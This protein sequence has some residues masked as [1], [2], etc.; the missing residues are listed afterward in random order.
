MAQI[1]FVVLY[2]PKQLPTLLDAWHKS[3][4]QGATVLRSAG[5]YSVENW[6]QKM[7][8][9]ALGDLFNDDEVRTKTV[10]SIFEDDTLL[11]QAIAAA[12]KAIGSFKNEKTGILFTMPVSYVDG[13][14]TLP[15]RETE[16]TA[17]LDPYL[18][19][20]ELVTRETLIGQLT[21]QKLRKAISVHPNDALIDVAEKIAQTP[22]ATIA[23]VVNQRGHL[24]GLLPLRMLMDDLFMAVVPEAFLAESTSFDKVMNFA[25]LNQTE[26]VG[27]AMMPP[28][29]VTPNNT[30]KDAFIRMHENQISGIPV[31]NEKQEVI[32]CLDRVELL[33]FYARNQEKAKG[34]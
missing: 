12:E 21:D 4:V 13:L 8:L 33:V 9:E 14:R 29:S 30:I 24:V 1:L 28:V 23:C 10:F 18:D 15:K 25:K 3:G 19:T 7:G 26:T 2:D 22:N 31:V 16:D 6:L 5:A 27:D 32:G 17:K 20:A 34:E 11:E